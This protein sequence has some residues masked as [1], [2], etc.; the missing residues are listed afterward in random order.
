VF[1]N[2]AVLCLIAIILQ[3]CIQTYPE[4]KISSDGKYVTYDAIRLL[5]PVEF[6]YHFNFS[7]RKAFL[8]S[9]TLKK[10]M[11]N[12]SWTFYKAQI[13]IPEYPFGCGLAVKNEGMGDNKGFWV[14]RG[15][16]IGQIPIVQDYDAKFEFER[17][18]RTEEIK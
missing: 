5:K 9:Q 7:A 16:I 4:N 2:I 11:T 1:K 6:T 13:S 17:V 14:S 15:S 3:G 10:Y 8:P 18:K 12:R